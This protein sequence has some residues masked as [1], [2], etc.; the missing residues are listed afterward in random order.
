MRALVEALVKRF[1]WIVIAGSLMLSPGARAQKPPLLPE[2]DVAALANELSGETAKRNL[3][4]IARFHRQRGSQGFHAAAELVAERLRAYGLSDVA[5]LQFPADGKIFYGTQRS[6]PSWDAAFGELWQ[7]APEIEGEG[8]LNADG[9]SSWAGDKIV[10]KETS[11]LASFEAE[12]VVLAED[13]ESA[14][15]VAKLV[16][17]SEGT[18]ESDYTAKEVKGRIVLVS[19]QPGAVQDLAVGKFGAVGIVSY[20]QNQKTAWWGEDENLIRWGH[21]E[22]FSPN[23][24][25]AFMVSLK[26]A[27]AMKEW[28]AQPRHMIQLRAIVKAAQ[29]QGNYEVVTATIPGADPKLKDEEIAFSCHLDHQRPGANDNASGCAT[30]LEVARTL[31]ELVN[32]KKLE[33]PARTIRF[34]FPPEIE[35]TL[36]LLNAKPSEVVFRCEADPQKVEQACASSDRASDAG[37]SLAKRIKA[38]VHMDMVGGGPETKAVFHV[39][40]GPMSLP[41]FVHD[42]AWS[43]AEWV[44]EESY[45]FAATGKADFPMIAPEGGKEPLR[46]EYSAYT[47]GSDHD[48]YQDS[49]FGIPAIYLNDWPDRYIHTNFDSAANIDPTKLKRVAFIGAA[50]GY[51]L[52]GMGDSS[53]QAIYHLL[54]M[55]TLQTV[56][57][58]HHK[59]EQISEDCERGEV[60]RFEMEQ[61]RP[62]VESVKRLAPDAKEMRWLTISKVAATLDNNSEGR[63]LKTILIVGGNAIFKRK[64]EPKGPLVVFGYDYFEDQAKAAGIATPKLMSYEGLWGSGEEYA[65]EVLNFADGKRSTQQIRDAV[66]AE[67]GPVPLELVVEYL[68]ALEKIGFVEETK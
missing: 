36:A 16:D 43:F 24:T 10:W 63:C 40:R 54:R 28:L 29:H 1:C 22:T 37:A 62:M 31:Q 46:A 58:I 13:S 57:E 30:I 64:L 45:K 27:R 60:E 15:L 55:R 21:L 11:R 67:Y 18:K 50:S 34:L 39:T 65:Y 19:A 35:G 48:V 51:F 38:V 23:K 17:V 61:V 25:F 47:M 49:S 8:G 6:R 41:S 44:N 4:G 5:I 12:P 42:V 2:K 26:R 52:A 68:K 32:E 33:R 59:R 66:S 9:K 53:L 20:A 7:V 56:E 3:E 14:D